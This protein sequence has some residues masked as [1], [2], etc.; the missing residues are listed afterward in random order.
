LRN[1]SV[2]AKQ[3]FLSGFKDIDDSALKASNAQGRHLTQNIA[4]FIY[5]L[6]HTGIR[7]ESRLGS[8]YKCIAGFV[9]LSSSV[10]ASSQFL[11]QTMGAEPISALDPTLIK[12]ASLFNLKLPYVVI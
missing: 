2:L 8:S 5:N 7:Y 1:E 9:A 6:G 12:V 4:A 11:E 10:A 3:A